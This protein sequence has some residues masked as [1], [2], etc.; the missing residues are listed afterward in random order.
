M[1]AHTYCL[2]VYINIA[3]YRLLIK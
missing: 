2:Y 1:R 3:L